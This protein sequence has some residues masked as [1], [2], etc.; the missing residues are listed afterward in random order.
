MRLSQGESV[1]SGQKRLPDTGTTEKE[2]QQ[3]PMNGTNTTA[4]GAAFSPF[5]L[6]SL[7]LKNRIVSTAHASGFT[8]GG[9]PAERYQAYHEEKAKGGIALTV[10]GGS[11]NIARDSGSIY[12][13]IYVGNDAVIPHFQSLARRVHAHDC[14][15]FCQI[16]HM[17][18][19]TSWQGGEWLST[20][21][22]SLVRDP[23]HHAL[24]RVAE[25]EDIRRVV[26]A[27]GDAAVRCQEGGLDGCEIL[28]SVHLLGQ[29]LSPLSNLREDAY[30]GDLSGRTRFLREVLAEVRSRVGE[31]FVVGLRYTA[32]ESNEGGLDAD[33]GVRIAEMIGGM[34]GVVDYINVNGAYGGTTKGMSE[35]FPAMG[36]PSG[37]FLELAKR[38]RA[39]SGLPTM[40]AARITDLATANFAVE[41]GALDLVGMV[42]P[43][44]ADPHLVRKFL[45]GEEA[46]IRPC[47]GAGHCLDRA[48]NVGN[49]IC[50]HNV[51]I[52]RETEFPHEIEHAE[53]ARK[54]VVVGGGPAGLEAARVAACRG[55]EVI[56]FEA[57]NRLGGQIVLA[58]SAGWRKDLIGIVDWYQGELANLG[59]DL[60]LNVYAEAADVLEQSPDVVLV[61]TG[62]VPDLEFTLGGGE[63]AVS[64]WDLLAGQVTPSGGTILVYDEVAGHAAVSTVDWLAGQGHAIELVTPDRM[65]GRELGG[66]TLPQYLE[67]LYAA[68][69]RMIPDQKLL[70]IE[71][72]GNQLVALL[73]NVYCREMERRP[74]AQIVVDRGTAPC[75]DLYHDLKQGSANAGVI[76]FDALVEGRPQPISPAPGSA[77]LVY[78]IGDAVSSRDIHAAVFDGHRIARPL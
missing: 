33:E 64:T 9:L 61:A 25:I 2:A 27:F 31:D 28:A 60:R 20:I 58:A 15:V 77:Y 51:S 26:K 37:P 18:R 21:A 55:H 49:M 13:Q 76:D 22:P 24:P 10:I 5:Q 36:T 73:Q 44:I 50:I 41:D 53:I 7:H 63:L 16:T 54:V 17:G 69:V 59:V 35:A 68:G 3:I 66:L 62:G 75:L 65:V 39:A 19:R 11:S 78:R 4:S 42:R 8:E 23:A 57:S 74:A 30:G 70:G 67:H 32:D 38:V 56:L 14:A 12:G 72:E 48:Y 47:V 34:T 45:M 6:R 52:G 40:Q 1:R 71:R 29:F 43:N 46:R